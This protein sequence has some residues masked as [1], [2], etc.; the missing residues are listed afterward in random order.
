MTEASKTIEEC[1][2][3]IE[4]IRRG[5]QWVYYEDYAEQFT[6]IVAMLGRECRNSE[7]GK[8][9]EAVD[10]II[11][12]NSRAWDYI[13]FTDG[14]VKR[15]VRSG[16]GYTI[17]VDDATVHEDSGGIRLT[18]SSMIMEIKAI[19]EDLQNIQ[20]NQQKRAII[21]TDSMCTLLKVTSGYLYAD[22]LPII[23]SSSLE[24]LT[25]SSPLDMQA[26]WATSEQTA[27]QMQQ[28]PT[29][30]SLS[31]HLQSYRS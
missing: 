27:S 3:S 8:T 25:G 20:H 10:A 1:G 2:I 9:D 4:S 15:G 14:S 18:T 23:T 24:K 13:V 6:K 29:A 26:Y 11:S 31:V 28:S 12:E 19:T 7:A 17:R 22:W 30:T 16:W 21:A 5:S